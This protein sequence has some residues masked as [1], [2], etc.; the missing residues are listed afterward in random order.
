MTTAAAA[1]LPAGITV[2]AALRMRAFVRDSV[3][4]S[5]GD[6]ERNIAGRVRQVRQVDGDVV[7]VDDIV[8]TG[9][10]AAE[11]VRTLQTHGCRVTAVVALAHA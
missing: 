3:G 1:A 6:R 11:S 4:L 9:S 10:T 7:L 8:T 2:Q 5:S